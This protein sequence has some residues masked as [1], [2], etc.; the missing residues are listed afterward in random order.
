MSANADGDPI[1]VIVDFEPEVANRVP[2][3]LVLLSS[4]GL[5][6]HPRVSRVVLHG[7]RGLAR[8][9]RADSDVDLTLIVDGPIPTLHGELE[10][11]LR[12]VL[13]ATRDVW[14][15]VVEADL[16]VVF[17]THGCAL[18]CFEARE[19]RP[20]LCSIGGLDCFGLYKEQRGF[21]GLVS[22]A[23]IEVRR[24]Y[25][26]LVVWRRTRSG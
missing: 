1:M 24:M 8:N 5:N 7:S 2:E 6:V 17:D 25:P 9:W 11:T 14:R 16:A 19:W 23:G 10:G 4:A 18:E 13:A 26:C 3:T 12:E 15:G 22:K 20:D 21:A